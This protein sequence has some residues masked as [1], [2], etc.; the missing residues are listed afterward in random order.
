MQREEGEESM[1]NQVKTPPGEHKFSCGEFRLV[2]VIRLYIIDQPETIIFPTGS[3][4][5]ALGGGS[6]FAL[7]RP[8]TK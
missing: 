2:N 4:G 8:Q 1:A 7:G 5:A 6:V 3:K